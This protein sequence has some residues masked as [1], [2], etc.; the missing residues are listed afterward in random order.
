MKIRIWGVRGSIPSP[1]KHEEVEDK[2]CRVIFGMPADIDVNDMEAVRNH[3]RELPPLI[4]GTAGGNTSCVEIQTGGE[5]LIIDAGS[6]IRELGLELMKGPC[7][8]GQGTLHLL[9][10][11]AHWDHIQ[12]FP[13]FLPAFVPGNRIFIYSIHDF[14]SVLENQQLPPTFPI[15]LSYMQAQIEFIA[16]QPENSFSIGKLNINTIENVH[17]GKA[18]SYRFE[19]QHS[20]FVYANDAE[21]KHLNDASVQPYIDFFR[22]ADAL[23]FD[24]QYTLKEAWHKV[25]WGHSSAMIGVDLARAAGVKKLILFHHDPTYSDIQLQE[26]QTTAIAYQAQDTTLPICEVIVGYEGLTIDLTPL[27]AVELQ[28]MPDNEAAILTPAS[29]FDERGANQ[30][31][32][33]LATLTQQNTPS[34]SIIDLSQVETLTTASLKSI[35]GLRQEGKG[36]PKVVLAGPS[37]TVLRVI[38]LAGY[39]DFFAIYPSV[40]AALSALQVRESLDLPGQ[41]IKN[42]YQ[43]ESK[44]GE[45]L[46]DTVLKAID[47]R[48][49]RS[50]AL[51]IISSSYSEEAIGRF[52]RQTQQLINLDH[53][54]IVKILRWD[55][56]ENLT[57]F[58]EEF[59]PFQTLQDLWEQGNNAISADRALDIAQNIYL[60]LEYA[61]SHG[62]IHGDLKPQNIFLTNEGVKL[63]D[64]GLGRLEEGRNLLDAPILRL[65]A[66]YLAPEQILG[67]ALDARVD[68]YALGVILYHLFTGQLPFTGNNDEIMQAH[69]HQTPRPPRELN[70]S[71]SP[72]LE[73]L[74]HKM[75][76]KNPNERYAS[77][78]QARRISS[79]LS[80]GGADIFSQHREAMIGRQE[81]LQTLQTVWEE[82]K[83]GRGQLVFITG[84]PGIGKTSLAQQVAV[85]SK[86]PVLLIGHCQELNSAPAYHPFIEALKIYFAMAP[87][88][89]FDEQAHQQLVNLTRLI[90]EIRQVLPDL[91]EPTPL[92]PKQE[93]LR[94]ISNLTQFIKRATKERPWFLLLEDLQWADPSSLELLRYLGHQLPSMA[95][96]IIGTYHEAELER[97]HP[98]LKT[99][100]SLKSYPTYHSYPL[101]RLNQGSVNQLLTKIWQRAVPASLVEK[102]YEQTNGNPFY[103]EEVAKGLVEDGLVVLRGQKLEFPMSEDVRL[104][105]SI[106]EAVWQRIRH[107]SPDTQTLLHQAA[108]L[109][110]IFKFTE[111]H[112]MSQLPE[113]EVLEHLTLAMERQLIQEAPGEMML[114]FSYAEIQHVLYTDLG[115]LRR[116][117][118]HR[119]AGE[120]L[121]QLA[122]PTPEHIAEKLAFHFSEAGES[123]KALVYSIQAARQAETAYANESAL[124]WYNRILEMLDQLNQRE[125]IQFQPLKLSVHKLLGKML[126]LMGRYDEALEHYAS[127][128][129][130]VDVE[131]LSPSQARQLA[132]LY[133]QTAEAYEKRSEY[134]LAFEWLERALSYLNEDEPTNE[135]ARIYLI[136]AEI[137]DHRG[138]LDKAMEWCN[139]SLSIASQI[140]TREGQQTMAKAYTRLSAICLLRG[141]FDVAVNF[142]R[143]GVAIYQQIDDIAGQVSSYNKLG[144]AYF[145]QGDWNHAH[146][147]YTKSLT[148]AQE[149]GDIDG[150]GRA[151]NNLANLYLYQGQSDRAM[152]LFKQS[153]AIWQQIG[154]A[155]NQAKTLSKMAQVYLNQE[156]WDASYECLTQSQEIFTEVGSNDYMPELDRRWGEYYLR[157]GQLDLAFDHIRSSIELAVEQRNPLDEGISQQS[158]GRIHLARGELDL[159]KVALDNSLRTLD[160]LNSSY[161]I[162]KT[163]VELV[164]LALESGSSDN[165]QKHLPQ[166]IKIFKQLGAQVDLVAAQALKEQ[167]QQLNQ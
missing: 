60:A 149:I 136:G 23:I 81:Q 34:R 31:A 120:A 64:F 12:G 68:L 63:S 76:A 58:V 72:S 28:L 89:F 124:V 56:E 152:T 77:A 79:G 21:Y 160:N 13:F 92:E 24:A 151:C 163:K 40:D 35:V 97:G 38:K 166:A 129:A 9:F 165:A 39:L 143:D 65:S 121:E 32:Q 155:K 117:M 33:Q 113:W 37:D 148:I 162:A 156:N 45:S 144:T 86:A 7:G 51:K 75:L 71:I 88:E 135:T 110:Q 91:P 70:P 104:P 111:L 159:A 145:Y 14:R 11:H 29:I 47:I 36:A 164:R 102:I 69:L 147:A 17:P 1:L 131:T 122:L 8:K 15:S 52:T 5:T 161:E 27:G 73:H 153:H 167:I 93:H 53:P 94:L 140:K 4:R 2:I 43:I 41:V 6:G 82:V 80:V 125:A 85:Q 98:L 132:D 59:V 42:R 50:L 57:F 158:L 142:T 141:Y 105:Q 48:T 25:D 3:V 22:N 134:N 118:L 19:D 103:V 61:H 95:L 26:I 119:Q 133:S 49:E 67:Q 109:G 30:L 46:M 66:P 154:I 116:R 18:Y 130:S 139:K 138:R 137:F 100:R 83:I 16:L 123:D 107:F 128:R 127:I 146:D 90:P 78:E 157:T 62:I 44:V 10:S 108:V 115:S 114:R 99:L 55:Q 106:H 101:D 84:E 54:N 87:P 112:K 74:I 150:H 96:M 126:A 20:V